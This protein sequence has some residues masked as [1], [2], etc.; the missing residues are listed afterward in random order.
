M[1]HTKKPV[2][3]DL[4]EWWFRMWH[5]PL[6]EAEWEVFEAPA[7]DYNLLYTRESYYKEVLGI[8]LP[9]S[10]APRQQ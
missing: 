8:K 7:S 1:D 5:Y 9:D 10:Q 3:F 2:R 4:V 6:E